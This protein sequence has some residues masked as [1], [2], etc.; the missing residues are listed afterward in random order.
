MA[1]LTAAEIA[2]PSSS[3]AAE[4]LRP[5]QR[6]NESGSRS[7]QIMASSPGRI[8]TAVENPCKTLGRLGLRPGERP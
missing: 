4:R 3:T 5:C 8:T 6:E 2:T 1:A 7:P